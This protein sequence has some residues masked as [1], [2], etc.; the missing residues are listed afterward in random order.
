MCR[1]TVFRA[2][3]GLDEAVTLGRVEPLH[4]ADGH[5][6]VPFMTECRPAKSQGGSNFEGKRTPDPAL[7]HEQREQA[8]PNKSDLDYM[9]R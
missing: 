5:G 1:K 2:V 6:G 7:D 9:G 4:S 8:E 3:V